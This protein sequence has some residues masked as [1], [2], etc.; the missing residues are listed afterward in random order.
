MGL[1]PNTAT[2]YSVY[3]IFLYNEKKYDESI[4]AYQDSLSLD[5]K[6]AETHYNLGVAYAAANNGVEA[7]RHAQAAYSLGYPLPGLRDQLKRKGAWK[8]LPSDELA[9][10]VS[11][12]Q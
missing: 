9:T 10:L 7:N 11:Q 12:A 3:G 4:K 1:F 2:T 6:S 5:P 8:P